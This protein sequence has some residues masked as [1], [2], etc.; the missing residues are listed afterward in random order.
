MSNKD[1]ALKLAQ[2]PVAWIEHHKAGDNFAW[3]KP[4]K[5]TPLYTSPPQRPWVDLTHQQTKDCM[6]AWDGKD[7]YVLCRAIE[8]KLKEKNT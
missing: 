2:E 7:A 4:N 1:E 3:K 8:A 5:G 6:A